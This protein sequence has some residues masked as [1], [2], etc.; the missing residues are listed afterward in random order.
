[1]AECY[2]HDNLAIIYA[3][4]GHQLRSPLLHCLMPTTIKSRF[5]EYCQRYSSMIDRLFLLFTLF[6]AQ[7]FQNIFRILQYPVTHHYFLAN[8]AFLTAPQ[9]LQD[10]IL[11][12]T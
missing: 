2:R 3:R 1:M 4:P 6:L 9:E 5:Q 11:N 10:S 7:R 8:E 12:A